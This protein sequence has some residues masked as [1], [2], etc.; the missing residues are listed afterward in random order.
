MAKN[1]DVDYAAINLISN[2]SVITGEINSTGDIRIDGILNGNL[3]TKG[4]IVIG[5]TGSVKGE[6]QCKNADILGK[7]EGKIFVAELL[8]LKSTAVITGEIKINRLSIE[9]GC[10]FNG[11][12][13]M[14]T[15][16]TNGN[17]KEE[18]FEK[19]GK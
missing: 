10:K 14:N 9:P 12:C 7:V 15:V 3:T 16:L 11:T 13:D 17:G 5:D 1:E 8:S 19:I 4:K 6:I 2:G 18:A